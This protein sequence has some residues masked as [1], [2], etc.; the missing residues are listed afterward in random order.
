MSKLFICTNLGCNCVIPL[1][2]PYQLLCPCKAS[3]TG[4]HSLH[5]KPVSSGILDIETGEMLSSDEI[6]EKMKDEVRFL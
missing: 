4:K 2:F 6:A 3:S 1:G 5:P